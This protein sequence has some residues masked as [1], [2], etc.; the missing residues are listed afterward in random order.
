MGRFKSILKGTGVTLLAVLAG[1]TGY[2]YVAPPELLRVGAGYAAKIVCSN[3]FLAGRDADTVLDIDV[4][5]QGNPILNFLSVDSDRDSRV[6]SANFL[7]F[8]AER[9]AIHRP[10][11]GCTVLD[12]G[13][14]DT[15]DL[16]PL[17]DLSPLQAADSSVLWPEGERVGGKNTAIAAL[18]DDNE[19]T[20]PNMRGVVVVQNG[21][22]IAEAYGE[23]FNEQTP[24]LGWSMTKTIT[25]A[26]IGLALERGALSLDDTNLFPEWTNDGRKAVSLSSLAAMQS[27]LHFDEAYAV[28]SDV[29]RMLFLEP[30]MAGFAAGMPLDH[31]VDEEFSYSSGT[32]VVL[33]RYW[34]NMLGEGALAFPHDALFAPLGMASAVMETDAAGTFVGSS[35]AYAT[36]R[37]WARFGQFLLN[38]GVWAGE[39]LLPE[40]FVTLMGTPSKASEGEYSLMQSWID[41]PGDA[42]VGLPAGTFWL[43]GHDGQSVAVVPAANLVVVRMGLTPSRLH[44]SP[45]P[46]LK[47]VLETLN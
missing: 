17:P 26:I 24:L 41:G 19:L 46:L 28:V 11:F 33:S 44:Y 35:Y 4:R 15:G 34:Q 43:E 10:G 38:D 3:V 16:P 13:L 30:D 23:G 37:D 25:G 27:G 22:I 47:K 20:G 31:A 39:R 5:S 40:G 14:G 1:A 8:I 32:S 21:R 36:A 9:H 12:G 45:K 29:T 7:G 18:L 2:L 42:P 6:V